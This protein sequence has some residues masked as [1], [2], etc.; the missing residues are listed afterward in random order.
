MT[1]KDREIFHSS[2]IKYF[3]NL[4]LEID[5]EVLD[6]LIYQHGEYCVVKEIMDI[7]M[8]SGSPQICV[9]HAG[10][11]EK[12]PKWMLL[13]EFWEDAPELVKEFL[14]CV[15]ERGTQRQKEVAISC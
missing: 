10:F 14:D 5:Q 1:N 13:N 9:R 11:P 7:G 3:R 4:K 2:R 8:E 12:D 15:S 6:Y